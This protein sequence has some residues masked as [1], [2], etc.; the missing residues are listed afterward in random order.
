MKRLFFAIVIWAFSNTVHSAEDYQRRP[1]VVGKAVAVGSDTMANMM[2]LWAEEFEKIY[3]Q[4]S[5]EIDV[6][7][8]STCL[9]YTS[10]S[11]RD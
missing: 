5:I 7:G 6:T 8:S 10:P 1:G 3:P 9:L 11:P 2:T 4:A